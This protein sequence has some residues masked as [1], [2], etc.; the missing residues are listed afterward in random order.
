MEKPKII[1]IGGLAYCG[2]ET[3]QLHRQE[4]DEWNAAQPR[5]LA[6]FEIEDD[7]RPATERSAAGRYAEPTS[8]GTCPRAD[9]A[10]DDCKFTV[11]S[12]AAR[13]APPSQCQPFDRGP[14]FRQKLRV[15]SLISD[16]PFDKQASTCGFRFRGLCP[17]ARLVQGRSL[18]RPPKSLGLVQFRAAARCPCGKTFESAAL[19]RGP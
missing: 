18:S 11:L 12:P 17:H 2:R 3:C 13:P 4:H 8:S 6:L 7:R 9:K 1:L 19:A 16:D 10:Q 14:A 5:Q 15:L